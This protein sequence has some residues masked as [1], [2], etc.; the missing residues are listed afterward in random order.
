[1]KRIPLNVWGCWAK[2]GEQQDRWLRMYEIAGGTEKAYKVLEHAQPNPKYS[3]Q[4]SPEFQRL[5][6]KL[7]KPEVIWIPKSQA[8]LE[9]NNL[10]VSEW[11]FNE[12]FAPVDA[13]FLI[14][15]EVKQE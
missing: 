3:Q 5:L 14:V 6:Q 8:K 7:S 9:G 2:A 11:L 13:E 15:Q 12:K 4:F 10:F 1:M